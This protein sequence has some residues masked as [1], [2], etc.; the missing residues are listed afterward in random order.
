M[1]VLVC[2]H[3]DIPEKVWKKYYLSELE[4]LTPG[5]IV[6][7][8]GAYGSDHFTQQYCY[9]NNFSVKICDKGDQNNIFY[10]NDKL[11]HINGFTS[12]VKRDEY[13]VQQCDRIITFLY[14]RGMSLGS[15][16]FYNVIHKHLSNRIA[17]LFQRH[18]RSQTWSDIDTC[19]DSFKNENKEKIKELALKHLVID[20]GNCI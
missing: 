6:Y 14:K 7:T 4:K 20:Y 3:V 17:K 1:A 18:A 9:N 11:E 10:S 5:N 15:G 13:M 12:Y 19:I 8:G 2:G 16:S